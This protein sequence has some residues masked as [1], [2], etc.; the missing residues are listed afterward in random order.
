MAKV[1][2]TIARRLEARLLLAH[3]VGS[4]AISAGDRGSHQVT[5]RGRR[6]LERMALEAGCGEWAQAVVRIGDPGSALED[7]ARRGGADV[8]ISG[9]HGRR[10]IRRALLGDLSRHLTKRSARAVIVVPPE[11]ARRW[12]GGEREGGTLNSIACGVDGSMM[13]FEAAEAA[14]QVA[15]G[16]GARLTLVHAYL[17]V[18]PVGFTTPPH[19]VLDVGTFTESERRSRLRLLSRAARLAGEWKEVRTVIR[20]DEPV[21]A[22]ESV[23]EEQRASLIIVG[24][25]GRGKL[26]PAV[27]GSTSARLT[28][29]ATRP[30]LVVRGGHGARLGRLKAAALPGPPDL[31]E[32]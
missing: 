11:A 9:S 1:A 5:A 24:S 3:V 6:F 10:S 29:S 17:S 25:R 13:G 30:V 8:V 7:L 31:T 15:A 16:L 2:T 19:R 22:I 12:E 32:R 4:T 26:L 28:V 18:S 21:S 14:G 27:L 20:E 23:A